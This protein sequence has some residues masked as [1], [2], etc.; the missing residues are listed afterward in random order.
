[1]LNVI[2][3]PNYGLVILEPEGALSVEDFHLAAN[4]IDPY[5]ATVGS[6]RGLVIHSEQFPGWDSF[7]ALIS[8]L[9]F[10]KNHHHYIA[11]VALLSNSLLAD[12]ASVLMG[13]FIR[14]EIK[15]FAFDD[16]EAAKCWL[17]EN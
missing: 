9:A 14:A 13:H 1:M 10:I 2:L 16:M 11:K 4:I 12:F 6:L 15:L 7:S 5:I 8:H 17:L 3:Q